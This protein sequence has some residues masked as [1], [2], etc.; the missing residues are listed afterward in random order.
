VPK[1]ARVN[2]YRIEVES[3]HRR[4]GNEKWIK[5]NKVCLGR[6]EEGWV[7]ERGESKESTIANKKKT[8]KREVQSPERPFL[9]VTKKIA[10]WSKF[11]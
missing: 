10:P 9:T 11:C 3:S 5:K 6:T 7:G 4:K 2:P 1:S 8:G